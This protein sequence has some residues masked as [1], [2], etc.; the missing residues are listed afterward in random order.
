MA[1][2]AKEELT[3]LD[4]DVGNKVCF[5]GGGSVACVLQQFPYPPTLHMLTI[6]FKRSEMMENALCSV[7]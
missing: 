5:L 1:I 7:L 2:V 4:I 3:A 6:R